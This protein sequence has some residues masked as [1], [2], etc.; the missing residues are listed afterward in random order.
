MIAALSFPLLGE[1][2]SLDLVNTRV[3][4]GGVDVDLLDTSPA[5]AAWL[6]AEA[7]RLP[8]SGTTGAADLQAVRALRDTLAALLC[9]R[10]DGLRPAPTALQRINAALATPASISRLVWASTGPR[11]A[12]PA[13]ALKRAA[14]LHALAVDAV[15]LL[16]GPDAQLLHICEHPDCVLQF[17]AR[18]PRRRWCSAS[19]C[20]NRA[21][22]ARHYLRQRADG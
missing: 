21:R 17:V 13:A 19:A 14:L 6:A 11:L 7:N 5:L 18:N 10:R 20:G 4:R 9:A 12:P 16:T 3:R 2:L 8:W 22:V 15:E 1:P